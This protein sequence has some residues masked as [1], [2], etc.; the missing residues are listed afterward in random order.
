M[1]QQSP[2]CAQ[3]VRARRQR[4]GRGGGAGAA[5]RPLA[6]SAA[7]EREGAPGLLLLL[8]SSGK[9][10]VR[11]GRLLKAACSLPAAGAARHRQAARL[12]FV[13]TGVQT[14]LPPRD[15]AHSVHCN[16]TGIR[17]HERGAAVRICANQAKERCDATD[18]PCMCPFSASY[19]C[20]VPARC[21]S[22]GA[23]RSHASRL[24][25][26]STA[27]RAAASGRPAGA[28]WR[29]NRQISWRE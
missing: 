8:A 20:M 25:W 6:R 1:R 10:G 16:R 7:G 21:R 14:D 28:A 11:A 12:D 17:N 22:S 2:H 9:R 3:Q 4:V 19:G 13:C 24:H 5:G 26:H 18:W 23:R 15:P 27:A 29:L